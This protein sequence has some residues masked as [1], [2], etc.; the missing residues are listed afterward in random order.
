M[1]QT[2]TVFGVYEDDNDQRYTVPVE[3]NSPEEAERKAIR[4]APASI[5]VAAV[6]A[7]DIVPADRMAT[8]SPIK[9]RSFEATLAR[10]TFEYVTVRLPARCPKCKADLRKED[11]LLQWDTIDQVW[12]ARIPRGKAS[13]ERFGLPVNTVDGPYSPAKMHG[14]AYA[15]LL[16][17]Q[18]CKG[19]VWNGLYERK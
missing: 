19:L 13:G 18:G 8:I 11:A 15:Y 7:G 2:Y 16:Q 10:L 1:K 17:C 12:P 14:A 5:I 9:G 3:A 4:Q 6:V